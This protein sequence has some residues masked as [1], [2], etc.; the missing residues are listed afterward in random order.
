M[1]MAIIHELN[2][3]LRFILQSFVNDKKTFCSA[4]HLKFKKMLVQLYD[5]GRF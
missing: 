1:A 4:S 2:D 3:G 5:L